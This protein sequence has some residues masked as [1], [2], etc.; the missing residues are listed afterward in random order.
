MKDGHVIEM[1]HADVK[2]KR[3]DDSHYV[4]GLEG[5]EGVGVEHLGGRH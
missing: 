5:D 3:V 4:E 1:E 2:A